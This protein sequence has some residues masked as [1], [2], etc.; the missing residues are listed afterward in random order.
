MCACVCAKL[1]PLILVH[2]PDSPG[3]QIPLWVALSA[4]QIKLDWLDLDI[5]IAPLV[6]FWQNLKEQYFVL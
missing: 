6:R 4:A 5:F 2:K 3:T 1:E